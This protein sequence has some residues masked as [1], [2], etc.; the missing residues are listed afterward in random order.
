M[1]QRVFTRLSGIAIAL[2]LLVPLVTCAPTTVAS[3]L[4]PAG[5]VPPASAVAPAAESAGMEVATGAAMWGLSPKTT[6]G[7]VW[8]D[9]LIEDGMVSLPLAVASL[10]DHVHLEV[11]GHEGDIE[12]IGYFADGEFWLRA[13][14]CPNCGGQGIAWGGTHVVCRL[15]STTFD[16]VTGEAS[17]G[18]R[19]YPGGNVPYELAGDSIVLSLSDLAE[20][21]ERTA[22]GAETILPLPAVIEDNDRGDRS[23]P[24]CCLAR[25]TG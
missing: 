15:C 16:P 8:A 7:H 13:C 4:N 3:G 21:Y 25:T 5:E 19:A 1:N 12:F 11:P 24:R 6:R 23:W 2:L 10:G 14:V 22:S 20:A 17:G 18:A 9:A